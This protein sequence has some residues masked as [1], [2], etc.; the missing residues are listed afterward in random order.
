MLH[1]GREPFDIPSGMVG[2]ALGAACD[3]YDELRSMGRGGAGRHHPWQP[4]PA[5]LAVEDRYRRRRHWTPAASD[6]DA[7]KEGARS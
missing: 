7:L 6:D 4:D 2:H 3:A 5:V 1:T